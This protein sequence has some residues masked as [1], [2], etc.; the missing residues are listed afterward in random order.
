MTVSRSLLLPPLILTVAL[1][2]GYA[3]SFDDSTAG[4]IKRSERV[5][6]DGAALFLQTRGTDRRAPVLLWLHGG[7][8]GPERPLFRYF[9]GGLEE[10]FVVAYWDQRG[11][12]LSYD[13]HADPHRLTIEQHLADLDAVVDHLRRNLRRTKI[14]LIGHSWGAALGLLYINAHP[15]KVSAF[16]GVAPLVSTRAAQQK[17]YDFIYAEASRRNDDGALTR[18]RQIGPPPH[19][20]SAEVLAME[21]LAER[22]GGVF[23]RRPHKVLVLLNGL[24][25]GLVTPWDIGRF[26]HANHV[27]LEAMNAELLDLHLV[28]SVPSVSVPVFF[29]LG[30]HDRHV[31]ANTAAT[32]LE[33]LRAPK[34]EIRW[35]ENSAHNVPF[36]EPDLFNVSVVTALESAGVHSAQ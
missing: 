11:A 25:R 6:T 2:V 13:P 35:F 3:S 9:N 15:D 12:G 33:E 36:E 21:A 28:S 7:P 10:H 26:I 31:D 19:K 22:Y 20:T 29:F 24:L 30:R 14:A 34:K 18:L 4:R 27:S 32:Y 1:A 23:H 17:Q 16:I 5:V 8:G